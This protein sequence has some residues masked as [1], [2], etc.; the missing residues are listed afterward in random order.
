PSFPQYPRPRLAIRSPSIQKVPDSIARMAR[1]QP[2]SCFWKTTKK[3][4]EANS[5]TKPPITTTSHSESRAPTRMRNLLYP[6]PAS[7]GEGCS[8]ALGDHKGERPTA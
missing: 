3:Y 5:S 6:E 7:A 4:Y 1:H 8:S 2:I